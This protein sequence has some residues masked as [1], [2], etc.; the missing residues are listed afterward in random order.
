MKIILANQG[1]IDEL[2]Y[3]LKNEQNNHSMYLLL[4]SI[5]YERPSNATDDTA[6]NAA[7]TDET[8]YISRMIKM[9]FLI[10]NTFGST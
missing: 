8:A 7:T 1:M 6:H 9:S 10:H 3:I 4:A 2:S 5:P